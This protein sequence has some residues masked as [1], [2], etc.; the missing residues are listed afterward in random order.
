M[1][2]QLLLE[3]FE[4]LM[5]VGDRRHSCALSDQ[6]PLATLQPELV[7]ESAT[8]GLA[9]VLRVFLP[10]HLPPL[11]QLQAPASPSLSQ[12]QWQYI[13]LSTHVA[14]LAFKIAVVVVGLPGS[15]VFRSLKQRFPVLPIFATCT[16]NIYFSIESLSLFIAV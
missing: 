14:Y 15:A 4:K 11:R 5:P 16:V 6:K 7:L 2:G 12:P 1:C 13:L 3:S 9:G 10:L 8:P